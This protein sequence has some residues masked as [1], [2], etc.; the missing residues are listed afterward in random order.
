MEL[1]VTVTP[2]AA[3]VRVPVPLLMRQGVTLAL[4]SSRDPAAAVWAAQAVRRPFETWVSPAEAS[5]RLFPLSA[6]R[7]LLQIVVPPGA[8][9]RF[10]RL[11][12]TL[13]S[14]K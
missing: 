2:G 1:Q 10:F 13:P 11:R 14:D 6:D 9:R 4:E 7:Q 12:A 5:L 3:V 8:A